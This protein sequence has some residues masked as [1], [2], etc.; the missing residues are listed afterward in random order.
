MC[1][2]CDKLLPI[3][4][5]VLLL[6]SKICDSIDRPDNTYK[7]VCCMCEYHT[8]SVAGTVRHIRFHIGDK[9]FKCPHCSHR[10][11]QK[12]NLLNHCM[13]RHPGQEIP[14]LRDPLSDVDLRP[15]AQ[16]EVSCRHCKVKLHN[17]EVVRSHIQ[18]CDSVDPRDGDH[19]ITCC[20]CEY[21]T[22]DMS[23]MTLHVTA[24]LDEK[25]SKCSQCTSRSSQQ[26]LPSKSLHVNINKPRTPLLIITDKEI[27]CRH[28]K[29]PFL[30]CTDTILSHTQTCDSVQ[31]LYKAHK[32]VCC[33]CDF[34]TFEKNT[35]RNHIRVHLGDKPFKCPY[36]SYCSAQSQNVKQHRLRWH[37][38][39][40]SPSSGDDLMEITLQVVGLNDIDMSD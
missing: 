13:R 29:Q 38:D 14:I 27:I 5:E 28:C 19:A 2:N 36:C 21:K 18:N 37:P 30:S 39:M 40:K 4:T 17:V 34:I 8:D 25:Q 20:I 24:H 22:D 11:T 16:K 12:N 31:R 7:Y 3:R 26:C 33:I 32:F 9:P 1:R 15:I 35:M 23:T 6:H 10:C